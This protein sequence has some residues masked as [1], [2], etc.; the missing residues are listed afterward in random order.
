MMKTKPAGSFSKVRK[1]IGV[2]QK[3]NGKA[4]VGD[5]GA[6]L[7]PGAAKA[8][9]YCGVLA[10]AG[11]LFLGMFFIGPYISRVISVLDLTQ[12]LML[13]LLV[14]SFVMA[15]KDI[16]T[17]LYTADDLELLLPMPFSA[18]QIVTAKLAVT[19]VFPVTVSLIVLNAVC[20]GLGIRQG[21]GAS[22]IIGTLLSSVL[23]PATGIS[24]AA[25]LVVILFRVF[26]FIRNRDITVALGGLF[27]FG[28]SI[29]YMIISSHLQQGGADAE[30]SA[31]LHAAAN[32]S[33]VFPNIFFMTRFMSEGSIPALLL[34]LA[35]TAALAAM[36]M[37]AVRAFYFST[38][39]SM[40]TT[41]SVKKAVSKALLRSG[42]KYDALWALTVYEAKSSRRNPAYMIY[43][44]IMSFLWP[45]LFALPFV[46]GKSSLLGGIVFPLEP[47]PAL[48]ASV[49][50][51]MAAS[52]FACGFNILPGTAFSRE[53]ASFAAIRA[54]PVDLGDYFRSKRRFSLLV[55]SL[56]SVMY[57]LL[58]GLGC[59]AA[60]VIPLRGIWTVPAGA[61]VCFLLN[62]ILIDLMLV[63]NS[64]KPYFTWDSETELSRKLGAVNLVAILI[65]V[66]MTTIFLAVLTLAP[67]LHNPAAEKSIL[68]GCAAVALILLAL[69]LAIDR[70]AG[71]KAAKNLM[72]QE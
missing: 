10:L 18:G 36:T 3:C 27:T 8:L 33:S 11:V 4:V 26:G 62:L 61:C 28:L 6:L 31:A 47:I 66:I 24:A 50:F 46:F 30:A 22:F 68:A 58:L 17:V 69:A 15:V 14:M 23:I 32:V 72:E 25:L 16:V 70:R 44:F 12:A 13:I 71:R 49:S 64:V 45:V 60:G 54:L 56:G 55:C 29:A 39:L 40:Q 38:A 52:C 48:A 2:L 5:S 19:S 43:G 53:G 7:S 20:L 42:R 65:G 67:A 37:L 35:V 34:S 59:I 63:K 57:V 9:V 41:G 51:G 21:A 1:L